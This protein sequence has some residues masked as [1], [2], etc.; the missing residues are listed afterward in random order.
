M[1]I[2]TALCL[3]ASTLAQQP[4]AAMEKTT[5]EFMALEAKLMGAAQLKNTAEEEALVSPD[6]AFSMALEG[7]PNYVLN[8][9]EWIKG[10]R[11]YDLKNFS[12]GD[13]TAHPLDRN[14]V[15]THFR[16]VRS[17]KMGKTVDMSGEF[18]MTDVWVK[19]KGQWQLLRR[20]VSRPAAV[21]G[22]R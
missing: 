10:I 13:L 5:S 1:P 12:I 7:R 20:F 22:G 15:V 16:L 18:V 21:P 19:T 9:S 11:Y 4:E 14:T 3:L 17:A 6:F 8:R 2:L